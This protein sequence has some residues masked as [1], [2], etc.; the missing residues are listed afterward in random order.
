MSVDLTVNAQLRQHITRN[1]QK[2]ELRSIDLAGRKQ[3]AVA[4]TVINR[5]LDAKLG[6]IPFRSSD[7]DQAALILTSRAAGLR[8]H[9]GQRAFPG[10]RIEAGE[11]PEQTALREMDEEVGLKLGLSS[12]LP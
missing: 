7:A 2:L 11:T 12:I 4:L 10:G 1:L 6:N 3:A 5:Q 8:A 9:A